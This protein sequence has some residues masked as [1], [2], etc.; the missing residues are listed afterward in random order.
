MKQTH[1]HS[2]FQT[3]LHCLLRHQA[4]SNFHQS[5]L[6]SFDILFILDKK[7]LRNGKA[8][9]L[10]RGQKNKK[11]SRNKNLGFMYCIVRTDHYQI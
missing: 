7:N 11:R 9:L 10:P 2:E 5:V 8:G 6:A 4:T 1:I 3:R